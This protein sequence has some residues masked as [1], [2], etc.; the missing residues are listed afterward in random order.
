MELRN[1]PN[2]GTRRRVGLQ[3]KLVSLFLI[4]IVGSLVT[5][6]A[7]LE[8]RHYHNRMEA[9]GTSAHELAIV[10]SAALAR[11]VWEID[12]TAIVNQLSALERHPDV[13]SVLVEDTLGETLYRFGP[14]DRSPAEEHLR[15]IRPIIYDNRAALELLG[16]VTI[17]FHTRRVE[18]EVKERII[19]DAIIMIV[20]TAVLVFVT[21]GA[22][23]MIVVTPIHR[24]FAAIEVWR[25]TGRIQ[26]VQWK[27]RDEVGL[28]I[29]EFN[30]MQSLQDSAKARL[31]HQQ[32]IL[33][34]IIENT[35]EGI[36]LIGP[37]ER[38][39]IFNAQFL[40]LLELADG[41]FNVGDSIET[42]I[43]KNLRRGG[44]KHDG[45][46]QLLE[47]QPIAP[48]DAKRRD[49][50]H[51]RP[52][53]MVLE[54]RVR[55]LTDG[56][57][58]ATLID[59]SDLHRTQKALRDA[60]ERA[61][62]ASRAKTE[63]L[64]H[65]SH[66]LRTPLNSIIGFSDV[67]SGSVFGPIGNSTYR[68]YAMDIGAS[69]RHLLGMINDILDI[70]KV[71]AGAIELEEDIFDFREV[72]DF[73]ANLM[74]PKARE[75][76]LELEI[77]AP[78][79]LPFKGDLR[80]CRQILLNLVSNSVKFTAT[81]GHI[82]ISAWLSEAGEMCVTVKDTGCGIPEE[83]QQMILEPFGQARK[84]SSLAHEGTGLG[85]PIAKRFVELHGGT[86]AIESEVDVGTV[87]TLIFPPERNAE[88]KPARLR[89]RM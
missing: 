17:T 12:R 73:T 7:V 62:F 43:H 35:P 37:D 59:V 44:T 72:L 24:L 20:A 70:S 87:V 61:E 79:P 81:D 67:M 56:S 29:E 54:I 16:N 74:A 11:P 51:F 85:L 36:I 65:M 23:H 40:D 14:I 4:T 42:L 33:N 5:L 75:K 58:V 26:T 1:A 39:V 45:L 6:F 89:Q 32:Q 3:L 80:L 57:K 8:G 2:I 63:F 50:T 86:L 52:N 15:A 34:R 76:N 30:E 88:A 9:L 18:A 82:D 13:E 41:D 19:Q 38:A 68:D 28:L 31:E 10:Q 64:A 69:G 84:T 78:L 22:T 48:L 47:R 25:N 71:E 83:D 49:F 53:G 21:L 55:Y 27:A 46:E 66:E 60:K 77:D